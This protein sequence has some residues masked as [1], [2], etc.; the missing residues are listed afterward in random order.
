M[1]RRQVETWKTPDNALEALLHLRSE[2]LPIVENQVDARGVSTTDN[3]DILDQLP[4]MDFN[5]L[6]AFDLRS[7]GGIAMP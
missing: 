4:F 7:F 2:W 1:M 6:F 3:L 5:D